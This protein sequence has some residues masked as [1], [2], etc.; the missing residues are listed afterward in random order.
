ML[1][2]CAFYVFHF[3]KCYYQYLALLMPLTYT[4]NPLSLNLVGDW[5]YVYPMLVQYVIYAHCYFCACH[6]LDHRH[7]FILYILKT[8]KIY[9]RFI[10]S[11]FLLFCSDH[12]HPKH[13]ANSF[14][15]ENL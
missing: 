9:Y 7:W 1:I 15:V 10:G 6:R 3:W 14:M 12:R 11:D 5:L 8:S 13:V 4:L 2:A